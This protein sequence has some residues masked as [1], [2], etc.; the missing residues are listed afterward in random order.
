MKNQTKT[1]N[2]NNKREQFLANAFTYF[3]K[4]GAEAHLQR[5]CVSYFNSMF[6]KFICYHIKNQEKNGLVRVVN[7]WLGVRSGIPDLHIITT[8]NDFYVELKTETGK[9]SPDQVAM[10]LTLTNLGKKVFVVKNLA[11]FVKLCENL[12]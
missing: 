8:N 4:M 6:P 7:A 10:H 9:L 12:T 2:P 5:D 11:D 1:T 3:M